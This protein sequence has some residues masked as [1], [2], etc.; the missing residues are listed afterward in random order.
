MM[1]QSEYRERFDDPER[2]DMRHENKTY[3]VDT[4]TE[5]AVVN[6]TTGEIK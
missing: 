4:H 5:D 2:V 1:S 3:N 6:K